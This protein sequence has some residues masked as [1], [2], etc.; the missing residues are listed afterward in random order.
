MEY[1]SV[2]Q[3]VTLSIESILSL[4]G[5]GVHMTKMMGLFRI[6]GFISILDASSLFLWLYSP[7]LGL[8]RFSVS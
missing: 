2:T 8:V 6:I 5:G 4:V 1:E 7:S 3:E